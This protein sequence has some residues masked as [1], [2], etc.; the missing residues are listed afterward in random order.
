MVRVSSLYNMRILLEFPGNSVP[1]PLA[2]NETK[3]YSYGGKAGRHV[4]GGN[5]W[6]EIQNLSSTELVFPRTVDLIINL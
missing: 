6:T 4:Q 5:S 3:T 1:R 2:P